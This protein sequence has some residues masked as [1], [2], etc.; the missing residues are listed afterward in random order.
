MADGI[1]RGQSVLA[2]IVSLISIILLIGWMLHLLLGSTPLLILKYDD[3]A[4]QR[5]LRGFFAVHYQVLVIIAVIGGL[6]AFIAERRVLG[7]AFLAIALI[8]IVARHI[9]IGRLDRLRET[10]VTGAPVATPAFRRLHIAGLAL[11]VVL[12]VAFMAALGAASAEVFSCIDVPPG[13]RGETC[14]AQCSLL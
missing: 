12:I 11:D 6:G 14:R 8:G 13:C 2:K 5:L 1:V 4:D 3:P 10:H 9:V 7:T